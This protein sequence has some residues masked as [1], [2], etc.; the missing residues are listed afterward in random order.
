MTGTRSA[1]VLTVLLGAHGF[2]GGFVG[3]AAAEDTPSGPAA[4]TGEPAAGAGLRKRAEELARAAS[5]RFTDAR[6]ARA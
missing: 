6:N 2:L 4:E 5:E 3:I 1:L